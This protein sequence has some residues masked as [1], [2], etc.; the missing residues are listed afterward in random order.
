MPTPVLR[1]SLWALAFAAGVVLLA[2]L[3]LPYAASTRLVR[4]RIA[5]E[6]SEWSGYDVAIGATPEISV[7]PGLRASLT[8]VTLSLPG[9]AG[10]APALTAERIE[11][12]LS[13]LAALAGDIRFSRARFVRPTIRIEAGAA[14]SALPGGGRMAR[15]VEE[16]RQIVAENSA[17]PNKGRLPAEEFGVVEFSEG[18][19]VSVAGA[20]ET[21]IVT[22]LAGRIDWQQLN[23]AAKAAASGTWR[24][25]PVAVDLAAASPLLFL[26]GGAAP[27]TVSLKSA[28]AN[29]AFDGTASLGRNPYVDGRIT[30][31]APSARR[32]LEWSRTGLL[33]E[34]TIGAVA[35]QSHVI[36]DG[37]RLRFEDAEIALDGNPAHGALDLLLGGRLPMLAGTLAFDTLDLR[38]FLAA[39]TPLDQS[40]GTG[41]GIIDDDFASQLNL[42]LR[43]SAVRATAG[44]I[45]LADLA[46]TTR[47]D[48]GLAAFDISD[49]SAFGGSIQAGLRFDRKAAGAQ[50]EMRLLASDIDGAAFAAAAGLTRLAPAG[51]GTV[52]VILKGDA[53][54]WDAL[55]AN[56]GGS[57]SA[58][59]GGGGLSG[60]DI[61]AL[62][63]RAK[64]GKPF[65][66]AEV[67]GKASAIDALE[68]K[69]NIASGVATIERAELRLPRHRITLGGAAPLAAG[70][71]NLSGTSGPPQQG[72][73][74][75]ADT[76]TF[77]VSGP[78]EAPVVTPG[79]VE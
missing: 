55:L 34:S 73:A 36:G 5:D 18:K 53:S 60:I 38:A 77:L 56:A 43:L 70:E 35:M 69:A 57:F 68:L 78:W 24:G 67:A 79:S 74:E 3:A 25:E 17:A 7:W 14:A 2:A 52:S 40:I 15:A 10:K 63:A 22:G 66:L 32:L 27:V 65:A 75:A 61:E 45:A 59:F 76:T 39:F 16:A 33:H 12:E 8:D 9:A 72:A 31:R 4:D 28:P 26:G 48:D 54:N 11:I 44:S 49:A 23:G 62:L 71:L 46:A 20:G 29:L 6:I 51:R 37:Q 30:F 41:P 58:S 47:V 13:A 64:D 42:D 19:I 50:V 1:R 21:E